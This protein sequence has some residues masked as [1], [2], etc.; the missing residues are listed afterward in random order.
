MQKQGLI[1]GDTLKAKEIVDNI[2]KSIDSIFPDASKVF[3]KASTK[4]RDDFLKKLNEILFE[5]NLADPIN[6]RKIDELVDLFNNVNVSNK[7][8]KI[9]FRCK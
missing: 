5:G 6:A 7:Q 2:T 3:G 8:N 4:E 9:F 1:S